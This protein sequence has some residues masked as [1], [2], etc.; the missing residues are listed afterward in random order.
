MQI[1]V[2]NLEDLKKCGIYSITNTI[3]GKQYI[4]S[5]AKSFKARYNQHK[6]KLNVGK[7][8][9]KHLQSAYLKYGGQFFIFKIEEIVLDT[10]NIR[11]IEKQYI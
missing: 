2:E 7:H 10:S 9:C 3:N 8:H 1:Q 11:N 4:G 6:S 5:T